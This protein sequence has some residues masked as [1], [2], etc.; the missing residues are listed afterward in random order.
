MHRCPRVLPE[1][2][3]PRHCSSSSKTPT[4]S[5]LRPVIRSESARRRRDDRAG[6][7]RGLHAVTDVADDV[8]E[9]T[10]HHQVALLLE[11][12]PDPERE[13]ISIAY[14][15]HVTYQQV[16]VILDM[17]EGTVKGRIRSGLRR[18]RS[19][20]AELDLDAEATG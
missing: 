17:P 9:T 13:A 7:S 8:C 15:G 10:V 4:A 14:S 6:H 18:M 19:Q 5:T 12:L 16:A 1:A 2:L 20:M 3:L 11:T